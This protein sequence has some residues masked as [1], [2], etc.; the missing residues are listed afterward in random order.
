[1]SAQP[2]FRRKLTDP[3]DVVI[4][5]EPFMIGAPTVMAVPVVPV[6]TVATPLT[7]VIVPKGACAQ[8]AAARHEKRYRVPHV[9]VGLGQKGHVGLEAG[10]AGQRVADDRDAEQCRTLVGGFLLQRIEEKHGKPRRSL[11][12]G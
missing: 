11:K 1:M 12:V 3:V 7:L 4:T 5:R 8:A 9:V 10:L 2:L 6:V